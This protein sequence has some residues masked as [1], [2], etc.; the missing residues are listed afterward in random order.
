[1]LVSYDLSAVVDV[2]LSFS[3]LRVELLLVEL[4]APFRS[5][6]TPAFALGR[7][8]APQAPTVTGRD[9]RILAA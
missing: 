8:A 4:T 2:V 9:D 1:M 6:T 7:Y 5:E 3:E